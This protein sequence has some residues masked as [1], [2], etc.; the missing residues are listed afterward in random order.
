MSAEKLKCYGTGKRKTAVARVWIT[1][2]KGT[3][4][5]NGQTADDYFHRPS[6]QI[7]VQ[8]PLKVT[9]MVKKIDIWASVEG[10][11]KSG[12]A[13]ALRHGIA[14]ALVKYDESLKAA[15]KSEGLLTRDARMKERKK[16]G[17]PV[18]RKRFQFCKR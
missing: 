14:R 13:G 2:G 9:D 17:Q 15:V 5:V 4:T 18:A 11:G 16:Y 6:L 8:Q 12:Q 10:G 1:S 3:I 7:L